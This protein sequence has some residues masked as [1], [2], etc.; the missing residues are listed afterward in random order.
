MKRIRLKEETL[1]EWAQMTDGNHHVDVRIAIAK[2]FHLD[3]VEDGPFA[4]MDFVSSYETEKK[5]IDLTQRYNL[6]Q[7][8]IVTRAMFFEIERQYGKEIAEKVWECL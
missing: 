5:L 8:C 4:G 1:K 6:T 7:E 2:R 3:F